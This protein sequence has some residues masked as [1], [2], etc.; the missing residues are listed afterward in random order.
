[1]D[2]RALLAA[3]VP[4]SRVS[5]DCVDCTRPIPAARLRA[6]PE[7]L[8]C[9]PCQCRLDRQGVRPWNC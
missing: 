1:M 5:A 7:A 8:R 9:V 6:A 2:R 4:P 3:A